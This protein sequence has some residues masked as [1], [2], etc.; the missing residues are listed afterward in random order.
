MWVVCQVEILALLRSQAAVRTVLTNPPRTL[1][2][3]YQRILKEIDTE[4]SQWVRKAF[5]LIVSEPNLTAT[6]L[7]K[8]ISGED[9]VVTEDMV[10][11]RCGSLITK[12]ADGLY[13]EFSHYTVREFLR[14]SVVET[15]PL[16][17]Y[18]LAG[19]KG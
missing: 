6:Q 3:T 19:V 4:N 9:I 8:Q 16:S 1:K 11:D 5:K 17:R 12:S 15:S 14:S 13:F 18:S 7:C 2:T 10:L